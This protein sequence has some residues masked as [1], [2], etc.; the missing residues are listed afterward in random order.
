MADEK[1]KIDVNRKGTILGVNESDEIKQVKV[2]DTY[3]LGWPS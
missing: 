2:E 1:S 3:K